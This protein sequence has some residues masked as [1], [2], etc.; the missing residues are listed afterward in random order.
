MGVEKKAR[1]P[2]STRSKALPRVISGQKA[3]KERLHLSKTP[4]RAHAPPNMP[5][6]PPKHAPQAATKR[7]NYLLR[8][9]W[10]SETSS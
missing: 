4:P 7:E 1:P 3:L 10:S 8:M 6:H 5:K 2:S 9:P